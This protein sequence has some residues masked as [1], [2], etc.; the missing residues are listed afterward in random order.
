MK[1][2]RIQHLKLSRNLQSRHTLA[3]ICNEPKPMPCL[4][5]VLGKMHHR[6]DPTDIIKQNVSLHTPP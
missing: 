2:S 5:L 6:N 3:G 4:R 1:L